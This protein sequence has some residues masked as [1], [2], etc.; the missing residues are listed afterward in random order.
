[1]S[2]DKLIVL[3]ARRGYWSGGAN[4]AG[5]RLSTLEAAGMKAV[6]NWCQERRTDLWNDFKVSNSLINEQEWNPSSCVE[7]SPHLDLMLFTKQTHTRSETQKCQIVML[8]V[9]W[10][11][12]QVTLDMVIIFYLNTLS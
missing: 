6:Q 7:P 8:K 5:T 11:K 4:P 3:S 12:I 9:T 2:T 1:M 10:E